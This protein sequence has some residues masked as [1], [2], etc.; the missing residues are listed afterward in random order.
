ML[1]DHLTV[2]YPACS[3]LQA[4]NSGKARK[5]NGLCVNEPLSA[6]FASQYF[7]CFLTKRAFV[8]TI[9]R[10]RWRRPHLTISYSND[11][12][13]VRF[14]FWQAFD[15]QRP[16][17][18]PPTRPNKQQACVSWR[19]ADKIYNREATGWVQ[20]AWHA[21]RTE[22]YLRE[23]KPHWYVGHAS[24]TSAESPGLFQGRAMP[25]FCRLPA[26]PLAWWG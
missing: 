16:W 12:A 26:R 9:S 15:T 25:D 19:F 24:A 6:S 5:K 8:L 20:Q 23:R 22:K 2:D 14:S 1:D 3:C 21:S 13:F 10:T 4:E 7:A 11:H 17:R 18:T